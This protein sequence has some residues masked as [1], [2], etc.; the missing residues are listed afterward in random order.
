MGYDRALI[1]VRH[2]ASCST[3]TTLPRYF[4]PCFFSLRLMRTQRPDP[5]IP[6]V[7]AHAKRESRSAP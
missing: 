3:N 4:L 7:G 5:Q 6:S 2:P 1:T